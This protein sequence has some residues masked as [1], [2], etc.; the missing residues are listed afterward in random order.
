MVRAFKACSGA[1]RTKGQLV[2]VFANKQPDAWETLA[3]ALIRSGFRRGRFLAH[4]DEKCDTRTRAM[5]SAALASSV[6]IVCKKRPPTRPGWDNIV[7]GEMREKITQQLRDFWDAGIRGPDFVWAATGPALEAFSKHPA[8]KK[9]N[10]P[11]QLNVRLG[12]PARGAADGGRLRCRACAV[13]RRSGG[14]FRTRRRDDLLPAAPPR[15][16]IGRRAG[17]RLHP[18]C[19]ILQSL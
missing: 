18:L 11:N 15:L 3:S 19:L 14:R 9:A 1:L 4:P 10:D 6:W 8:V 12:V 5:T 13:P 2:V 7:L 17:R 16:R